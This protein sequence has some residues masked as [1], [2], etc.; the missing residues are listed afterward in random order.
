MLRLK[1]YERGV[2][3]VDG[4]IKQKKGLG[5]FD[6]VCIASGQV[7]GAGVVTLIGSAIGV[8]GISAWMAYGISVIV[9]FFSIIP[10]I[11]LSSAV[12]L[13]GGE[14]SIVP[15]MLG[16]KYAGI[17]AV[18]FITQCLSLSLMG[19]SMGTYFASIFPFMSA[20]VVGVI[21]VTVFF[22]FNLLGITVMAK[23][24][25]VLTVILLACL[26]IFSI[27]GF[28]HVGAQAFDFTS[29]E[30][31]INGFGGF[32]SAVSLYAY[33]TYGQYLVINFGQ[34]AKN[35]KRD[36]P[37]AIIISTGIILVMYVSIA[38]VASGILPV[39]DTANQPLT[40]VANKILK[41]VLFPLFII[42]GPLMALATTLNSTYAARAKPLLRAAIDGWF[43]EVLTKCNKK[44]VPY[45]I[46][47][48]IY[49]IGIL[50]LIF[51]MSIKSI[52]NN[53]VL[54]GY[55]L[56]MVTAVAIIKLP[57][58]YKEQWEKSFIHIPNKIF[59]FVMTL[60]CI[61]QL[62]MVYLSLKQLPLFVSALNLAVLAL[63]ALF[64]V[65]RYRSGKVHIHSSISLD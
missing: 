11:F 45:I 24:Q 9:G 19:V 42:G 14:Y 58:L 5:L 64:A 60:T 15:G 43:P 37:L 10:F 7:I 52:T 8:T 49:I 57:V 27:I 61:A 17:Y 12:V 35:P 18:A 59:Y 28:T 13:K 26:L 62:Y 22:V 6:L 56:R 2:C 34:E 50:P 23:M 32:M 46:M 53:L 25:K 1:Y 47:L 33:S 21:S 44:E 55:L 30:F 41:G 36:I 40:L 38:I 16:E 54:I 31:F 20:Q 63:C 3:S 4:S 39:A 65:Y 29:P 48:L 51:N